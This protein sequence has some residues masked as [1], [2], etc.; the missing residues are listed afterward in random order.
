[1]GLVEIHP[2]FCQP[3][4]SASR[5][6]DS[7]RNMSP[8]KQ[9][10]CPLLSSG[11]PRECD[12]KVVYQQIIEGRAGASQRPGVTEVVTG[13]CL[14]RQ[15]EVFPPEDTSP[16]QAW[17][18][19]ATIECLPLLPRGA[20]HCSQ[21]PELFSEGSGS[22]PEPVWKLLRTFQTPHAWIF[23]NLIPRS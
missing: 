6:G 12:Y 17:P 11:K 8:S 7:L 4:H 13:D 19:S 22:W 16:L 5:V 9:E 18:C 21:V 15:L 3:H 14:Q 2:L 10:D 23:C 20:G 1:M